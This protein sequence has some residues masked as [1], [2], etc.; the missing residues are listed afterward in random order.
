MSVMTSREGVERDWQPSAQR[1]LECTDNQ[2]LLHE[3]NASIVHRI[4]AL[5][6]T[7]QTKGCPGL[8]ELGRDLSEYVDALDDPEGKGEAMLR[9]ERL[10][11][12]MVL[13]DMVNTD[14]ESTHHR[15]P[16][17]YLLTCRAILR[18]R[19]ERSFT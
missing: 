1:I 3:V 8:Q 2:A 4:R 6:R 17:L 10:N 9:D 7:A 19:L 5:L 11:A 14:P 13:Y 16:L 18:D 15:T 12:L